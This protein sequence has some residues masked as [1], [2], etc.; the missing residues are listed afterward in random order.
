MRS[1]GFPRYAPSMK[2][3]VLTMLVGLSLGACAQ[4]ESRGPAEI[5]TRHAEALWP[6]STSHSGRPMPPVVVDEGDYWHVY[7]RLPE[8]VMGGTPEVDIRK[9]DLRVV[10]AYQTQ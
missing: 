10:R 4:V 6:G 5:A 1:F 7:F 8:D 2:T 9:S 3:A